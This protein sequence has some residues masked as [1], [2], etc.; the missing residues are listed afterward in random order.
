[1]NESGGARFSRAL[2]VYGFWHIAEQHG[3]GNKFKA[4][5][6]ATRVQEGELPFLLDERLQV[7]IMYTAV[8]FCQ[9]SQVFEKTSF[10]GENARRR[11]PRQTVCGGEETRP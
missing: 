9:V 11:K 4:V 8:V 2:L 7:R 5:G 3:I 6:G 10:S 1:M